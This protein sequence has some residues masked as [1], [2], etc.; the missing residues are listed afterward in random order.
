MMTPPTASRGA[1]ANIPAGSVSVS[2]QVS[3]I[4]LYI[5]RAVYLL[6]FLGLGATV[7]PAIVRHEG[8]WD[9]YH[10][11]AY[12]F[13]AAL[14]LLMGLGI[15]YPLKMLPLLLIQLAYKSIWLAAIKLPTWLAGQPLGLT[16]P[17]LF[18]VI[19]DAAVIPW[20]HVLTAYVRSAG[21]SWRPRGLETA[22]SVGEQV[23]DPASR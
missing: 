10:G 2:Q 14:S 11:V 7:W 22:A 19:V 1:G 9:P 21:D 5:L 16:E 23:L 18:G 13:W 3:T 6:N 8:P 4:R 20:A 17:M 12:S 15:R